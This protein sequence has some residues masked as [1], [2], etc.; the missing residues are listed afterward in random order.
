MAIAAAAGDVT[1]SPTTLTFSSTNWDTAQT[2]TVT[3]AHDTDGADDK[4]TLTHTAAG[5]GYD[6]AEADVDVTV[7]DDDAAVT[8][9]PTLNVT[10]GATA[11]YTVKL[12]AEP[13]ADVTVAIAAAAGDVSVSPTT[14]T[15]TSSSWDTAQTVTVT[16]A[17]DTDAANHTVTLTHTAS[18]SGYDATADVDVTVVDD[19]DAA[20]DVVGDAEISEDVQGGQQIPVF[21]ASWSNTT[22]AEDG[23]AI[24]AIATG[25]LSVTGDTIILVTLHVGRNEGT[26]NRDDVEVLDHLDNLTLVDSITPNKHHN[27]GWLYLKTDGSLISYEQATTKAMRVR[28]LNDA[29]SANEELAVWVYVNGYLAGSQTLS[30]TLS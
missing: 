16:A 25:D 29:D 24:L 20:I 11:T 9:P 30:L 22:I 19:D 6:D 17:H 8:V 3:A 28:V 10:E 5:S 18:G 7:V 26:A 14:L 2:V 27:G 13:A 4:V 23:S 12:G 15:F 21:T 1:V